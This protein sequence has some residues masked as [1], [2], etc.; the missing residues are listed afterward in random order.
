MG[1]SPARRALSEPV[2]Y[3]DWMLGPFVKQDAVNPI[4]GAN[5]DPQFACPVRKKPVRWQAR[6]IVGAAAMVRAGKLCLVYHAEDTESGYNGLRHNPGTVRLGLAESDDGVTFT[7][8]PAPVLYPDD[9]FMAGAEWPGGCE[10]P[11]I[12]EGPDGIYYLYYSAWNHVVTRLAVATSTDLVHWTK[13]GLAFVKAAGGR[14]G[15]LWSKA[16][17][18]VTTLD[19]GRLVAARIDGAYWMYWGESEVFVAVSNNLID[20]TPLTWPAGASEPLPRWEPQVDAARKDAT[21]GLRA[22]QGPRDGLF[23]SSLVEGG[24]AVL[25]AKGI[26]HIYNAGDFNS[27]AAPV[28]RQAS[29][30]CY[31]L[32]QALHDA[33]DP[34][35]LLDRTDNPFLSP[36]RDY[37]MLGAVPNVVYCTGLAYYKDRWWLYYNGAD[38]VVSVAVAAGSSPALSQ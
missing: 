33:H 23:D 11:R 24:V 32:G 22:V 15:D 35:I 13:R 5:F 19:N 28:W 29:W 25:T 37:E 1:M 34:A 17:A 30:V 14:Y 20:W 26:V 38:W 31:N 27:P 8:R 2:P 6:T 9:D 3:K 12:V 4:L 18:V 16:G 21:R 10:I 7:R 36:D